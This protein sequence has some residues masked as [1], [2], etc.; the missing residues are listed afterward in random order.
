MIKKIQPH[1][2]TVFQEINRHFGGNSVKEQC[3]RFLQ[4]LRKSSVNT[5]EASRILGIYHPPARI[6]QLRQQGFKN[7]FAP[8]AL[9]LSP[10]QDRGVLRRRK[11]KTARY[12]D[13]KNT[14]YN[15]PRGKTTGNRKLKLFGKSWKQKTV[16][17]IE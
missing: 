1:K 8:R 13:F 15:P 2:E 12:A 3:T 10:R 5:F 17:S 14:N 7:K 9:H 6:L 11:P 4:S 16:S